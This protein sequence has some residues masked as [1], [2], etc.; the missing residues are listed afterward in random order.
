[1]ANAVHTAAGNKRACNS[2]KQVIFCYV[3]VAENNLRNILGHF[4]P[5]YLEYFPKI[6]NDRFSE[7]VNVRPSL[8]AL[9]NFN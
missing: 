6:L 8:V 7:A 4:H 5:R 1:M 2:R 3:Y 9:R